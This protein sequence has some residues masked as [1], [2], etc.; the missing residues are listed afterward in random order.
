M[1]I[2]AISASPLIM[3]NDLRKVPESS[4]QILQNKDAI[5][6]SQDPLGKM[7][8]RMGSDSPTQVWSRELSNGDVAVAL[9][10]K[11][12]GGDLPPIPT[13]PCQEWNKTEGGY[14]EACGGA[15]GN[16][17]SFTGLTREQAQDACC[18][19][20]KCAGFDFRPAD[21]SGYYKGDQNCGK[22][23]NSAYE[24]YTK[25]SQMPSLDKK[26]DITVT[27]SDLG[28]SGDVTVYDIWAQKKIGVFQNSWTAKGV[29]LHDSAFV[30]L[31]SSGIMI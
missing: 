8:I 21:G 28:L 10:N 18:Q 12:G 13:G 19:N 5:A 30:R 31:S 24:G 23:S 25:P 15:A 14:L 3:G 6:V 27:F 2:W 11:A 22:V 26:A 7:G 9:Y 16:V 1:A 17:G 4:R 20:A 29:A